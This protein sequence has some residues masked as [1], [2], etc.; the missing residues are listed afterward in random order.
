MQIK[1]LNL[2][3]KPET[4]SLN[5]V[6]DKNVIN[7][8]DGSGCG[9]YHLMLIKG[10][11]KIKNLDAKSSFIESAGIPLINPIVDLGNY[12]MLELGAPCMYLT[13]PSYLFL[14]MLNFLIKHTSLT[15]IGGM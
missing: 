12:V 8:I 4:L 9:N 3:G 14:L 7:Q 6:Q 5:L 10:L 1:Q 2:F 13:W 11:N 15:V